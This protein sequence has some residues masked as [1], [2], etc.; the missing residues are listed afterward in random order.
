MTSESV[1]VSAGRKAGMLRLD[2]PQL[3]AG[4]APLPARPVLGFFHE[5]TPANPRVAQEASDDT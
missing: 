4:Q 2:A 3:E 1:I 5:P